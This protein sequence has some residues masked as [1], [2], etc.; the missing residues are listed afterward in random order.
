MATTKAK[1]HGRP[2]QIATEL[3][4]IAAGPAADQSYRAW[5]RAIIG[6]VRS[7]ASHTNVEP[8]HYADLL[9]LWLVRAIERERTN[10]FL[11]SCGVDPTGH[12][13]GVTSIERPPRRG[14][15]SAVAA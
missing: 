1:L 5:C 14:R 4:R 9:P 6:L 12:S 10:K 13:A 8:C 15:Q 3:K 2:L 11:T 7:L